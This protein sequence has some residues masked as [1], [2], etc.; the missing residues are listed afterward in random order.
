MC[1]FFTKNKKPDQFNKFRR[2]CD[3]TPLSTLF[4]KPQMK[5]KKIN[6]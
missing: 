5:M 2:F 4:G 3:R 6:I 1:R